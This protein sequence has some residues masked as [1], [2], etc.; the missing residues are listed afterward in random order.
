M[1]LMCVG[2]SMSKEIK[3]YMRLKTLDTDNNH[4][5]IR[6]ELVENGQVVKTKTTT[7]DQ[8]T[9]GFL[10]L[11]YDYGGSQQWKLSY[12]PEAG[13]T[14][15]K[16]KSFDDGDSISG[17]PRTIKNDNWHFGTWIKRVYYDEDVD[18]N[19]CTLGHIKNLPPK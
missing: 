4:I 3:R 17:I 2:G 16:C 7:G 12:V 6:L 13:N 15:R 10:K 11:Q 19:E 9:L 18:I 8:I 14:G 1:G 5:E